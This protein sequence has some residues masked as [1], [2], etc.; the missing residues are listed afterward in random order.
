MGTR[1]RC[2]APRAYPHRP[3]LGNKSPYRYGV[4]D[5]L[6]ALCFVT[7]RSGLANY[8]RKF[9]V[10]AARLSSHRR[11]NL[12]LPLAG[13]PLWQDEGIVGPFD[14]LSPRGAGAPGLWL[15]AATR[16]GLDQPR[17]PAVRLSRAGCIGS[18]VSP[19]GLILTNQPLA[20]SICVQGCRP[21]A[22][23]ISVRGGLHR[24]RPRHEEGGACHGT[25]RQ[26]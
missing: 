2:Q 26:R 7:T 6:P 13:T 3:G 25:S 23:L 5:I 11:L 16:H 1:R 20:S 9:H 12:P 8:G 24:R 19:E 22:H 4:Q 10:S 14:C 15:G 17:R 21:P 18:Y